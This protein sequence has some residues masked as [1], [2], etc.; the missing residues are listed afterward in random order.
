L[1]NAAS[2]QGYHNGVLVTDTSN[3]VTV[4]AVSAVPILNMTITHSLS[5]RKGSPALSLGGTI[6]VKIKK[7]CDKSSNSLE[8]DIVNNDLRKKISASN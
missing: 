1:N 8:E 6:R 3:V 7:L 5:S 2:A 4:T